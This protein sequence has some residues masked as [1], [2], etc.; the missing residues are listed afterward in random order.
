MHD[1]QRFSIARQTLNKFI[2]KNKGM[3]YDMVYCR[4]KC[5]CVMLNKSDLQNKFTKDVFYK[6]LDI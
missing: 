4:K 1:F 2:D 5:L 3:R 6:A